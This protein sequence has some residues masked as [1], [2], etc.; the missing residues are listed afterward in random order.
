MITRMKLVSGMKIVSKGAQDGGFVIHLEKKSISVRA[1]IIPDEEG[2]AFVLRLLDPDNV[3]H[4]IDSLGIHPVIR[5]LF[6]KQI[7]KPNGLILTTGPTGSGK[8]TTLYSFLNYTKSEDIKIITLED[9]IEYRLEGII[10]T[11]IEKDYSFASGLRAI[12]RQDPDV[13][14]VGEIRD[15]EVADITIQASLTGHLVFSTLHTN[16]AM[17]ALPRLAQFNL[18]S[19]SFAKA[20]NIFDCPK[21]G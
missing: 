16:D 7:K 18:E 20:I 3:I 12:L 21:I 8:T 14:L 6:E 4:S 9:P 2:G 13:I 17:G 5:E 1:S 10:Q 19:D 11:P 15:D